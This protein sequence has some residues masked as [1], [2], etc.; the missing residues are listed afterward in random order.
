MAPGSKEEAEL[1]EASVPYSAQLTSSKMCS[2]RGSTFPPPLLP[3]PW[4]CHS[5]GDESLQALAVDNPR[6]A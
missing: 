1:L 6:Q 5:A 3:C 2:L 4:E